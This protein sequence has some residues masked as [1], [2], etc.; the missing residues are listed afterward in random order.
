MLPGTA[1]SNPQAQK[2]KDE[3]RKIIMALLFLRLSFGCIFCSSQS[4]LWFINR[5]RI[6][7]SM[8][9]SL[10]ADYGFDPA[11][12]LA[13]LVDEIATE[14]EHDEAA[15]LARQ[16]PLAV[17]LGVVV[18]PNPVPT[19]APTVI[20]LLPTPTLT[21]TVSAPPTPPPAPSTPAAPTATNVAP[22]P[23]T[24]TGVAPTSPPP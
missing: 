14:A 21:P 7:A 19:P 12:V 22:L 16:T 20:A 17:G 4:A 6:E 23:P 9:S 11:L 1:P 5:D 8:R 13:P 2:K 15:L 18:L 10:S 3:R 24:S